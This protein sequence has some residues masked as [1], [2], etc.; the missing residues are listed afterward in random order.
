M[1]IPIA[2]LWWLTEPCLLL[3]QVSNQYSLSKR[4][5][6]RVLIRIVVIEHT[7]LFI[8]LQ[9]SQLWPVYSTNGVLLE[10]YRFFII[11]YV[12]VDNFGFFH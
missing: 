8:S 12:D 1:A 3:Q 10:S 4:E 6:E 11:E 2:V 7:L 9:I 5:R